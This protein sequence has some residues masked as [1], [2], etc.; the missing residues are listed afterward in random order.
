MFQKTHIKTKYW[1]VLFTLVMAFLFT[2]QKKNLDIYIEE[3]ACKNF[4][5]V[6]PSYT[7]MVD[8]SCT[9]TPNGGTL[10]IACKYDGK[11]ECIKKI[12]LKARFYN[13]SNS[14]IDNVT[15]PSELQATDPMVTITSDSIIFKLNYT[16]AEGTN[17][18]S[19]NFIY[20][21][22]YTENEYGDISK[23]LQLR[24]DSDCSNLEPGT[25]KV[26]DTVKVNTSIVSVTLWDDGEED[27]DIVSVWINDIQVLNNFTL[28]NAG[29]SF[30]FQVQP[31]NNKLILF[32]INEG[33]VGPNT[34][35]I[36]IN[37]SR[38]I[39]LSPDLLKGE[40]VNIIF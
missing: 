34:A 35:A 27:G 12:N 18:K 3:T 7:K 26:V 20:V 16:F 11:I 39:N 6:N 30:S 29:N 4:K 40:A 21:N 31:G 17:P 9:G 5:I 23:K 25:Y 1:L 22:Y 15:Y 10:R 13:S 8:P 32:A 28:T 24:V 33:T 19:L 38:K 2:C 14:L 37:N 36:T